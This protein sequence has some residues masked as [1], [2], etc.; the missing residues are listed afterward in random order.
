MHH[1]PFVDYGG[2]TL[3]DISKLKI[4]HHVSIIMD[5]NGRWAK[6]RGKPRTFGHIEGAK[7]VM[8]IVEDA[9]SLGIKY[10]TVYA[11]STENWSRP[12]FEVD[13]LMKLF[14][15]YIQI[16]N[17]R[18]M[19][20]NTRVRFIG[21]RSRLSEQ[22]QGLITQTEEN[23]KNNDGM[24]FQIAINY[25]SRDEMLR[26]MKRMMQDVKNGRVDPENLS[27]EL[28]ASYLD[29]AGIPDP[30]LMIRTSGE[31]RLSNWMMWQHS[32]SEFY[33]T[34]TPWPDFHKDDLIEAIRVY[35]M[36]D[37]RFGNV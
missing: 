1:A 32:Y 37:R 28:Y 3:T 4:P 22:L 30:D 10:L 5:G 29:T 19:E 36:R 13:T 15:K 35:T 25:G 9:D 31:M 11:F 7:N 23:T 2:V 14:H 33:F 20:T 12:L 18:A 6:K 26:A 21:E 24:Q 27:Q 34:D 17:R 16:C 8:D